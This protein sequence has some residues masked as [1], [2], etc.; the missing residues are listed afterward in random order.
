MPH[1]AC[2]EKP[3]GRIIVTIPIVPYIKSVSVLVREF[4]PKTGESRLF[5][6]PGQNCSERKPAGLGAGSNALNFIQLTSNSA[7]TMLVEH[8]EKS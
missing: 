5:G 6:T 7:I 1:L 4:D 2:P 8:S 3:V